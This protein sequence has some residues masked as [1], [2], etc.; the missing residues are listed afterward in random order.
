MRSQLPSEPTPENSQ[1]ELL[2]AIHRQ[3]LPRFRLTSIFLLTVV[4]ALALTAYRLWPIDGIGTGRRPYTFFSKGYSDAGW[5]AIGIG[6]KRSEVYDR[7]GP[8]TYVVHIAGGRTLEEW[9][10]AIMRPSHYRRR[11]LGF[12]GDTVVFKN[13]GITRTRPRLN[14]VYPASTPFE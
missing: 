11:A 4:V 1:P 8:P 10:E 2:Q 13:D 5:K 3:S 7:L 14:I 12:R 9:S 6:A